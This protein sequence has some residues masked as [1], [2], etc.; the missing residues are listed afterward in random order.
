[1]EGTS[2]SVRHGAGHWMMNAGKYFSAA[3]SILIMIALHQACAMLYLYVSNLLILPWELTTASLSNSSQRQKYA[4]C[5][6]LEINA[7]AKLLHQLDT[8][9]WEKRCGQA[10][11]VGYVLYWFSN[12]RSLGRLRRRHGQVRSK[13]YATEPQTNSTWFQSAGDSH[14][15]R[16]R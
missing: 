2:S 14:R 3:V 15:S 12:S 10:H 1:M 9:R 4:P 16:A 6:H 5:P 13:V 7:E 11:I 8:V